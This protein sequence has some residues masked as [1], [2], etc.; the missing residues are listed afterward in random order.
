MERYNWFI[1]QRDD[2]ELALLPTDLHYVVFAE[3]LK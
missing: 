1:V 3:E 2:S